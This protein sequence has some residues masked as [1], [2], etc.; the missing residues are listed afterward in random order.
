M[1]VVAGVTGNTGAVVARSL[2]ERGSPVRVLVRSEA[3]GAPWRARG[4]EVAVASLQDRASLARALE[5]AQGF[6]F[7]IPPG[8]TAPDLHAHYRRFVGVL[9]D[10]LEDVAVPHVVYLSSLGAHLPGGPLRMHHEGEQT[11][12]PLATRFTFLRPSY[13]MENAL[14]MLPSMQAQG[15]FPALIAPDTPVGMVCARDIGRVAAD[16]LRRPPAAT[17]VVELSGPRD[18]SMR[19]LARAFGRALGRPVDAV[20]V[21]QAALADMFSPLGYS[22]SSVEFYREMVAA[23]ESRWLTFEGRDHEIVR[24]TATVDS[25]AEAACAGLQR[26]DVGAARATE[27]ALNG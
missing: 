11:L 21:P 15:V 14:P 17:Q 8:E 18:Y 16:A 10:A 19:E 12:R 9:R 24:G 7:V 2:L 1:Y 6:Y 25:F 23:F 27:A 13:F 5:G 20:H 26:G 22:A 4:A 3:K